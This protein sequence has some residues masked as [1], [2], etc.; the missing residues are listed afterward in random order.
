[1]TARRSIEE[2][3]MSG[4][5]EYVHGRLEIVESW[6]RRQSEPFDTREVSLRFR[7][8]G[9]YASQILTRLRRRGGVVRVQKGVYRAAK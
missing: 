9:N 6:I 5:R 8:S 2:R 1:M 4:R 3:A 7:V